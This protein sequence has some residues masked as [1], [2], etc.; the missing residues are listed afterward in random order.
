M[1]LVSGSGFHSLELEPTTSDSRLED[2][3]ICPVKCRLWKGRRFQAN[4][5]V[6]SYRCLFRWWR[7][8]DSAISNTVHKVCHI[9]SGF[10]VQIPVTDPWD[11]RYI[12]HYLPTWKS[13]KSTKCSYIYHTCIL[14]DYLR[15]SKRYPRSLHKE[16]NSTADPCGPGPRFKIAGD[17]WVS[18]TSEQTWSVGIWG[19]KKRTWD[20]VEIYTPHPGFQWQITFFYM[21]YGFPTKNV[22][23]RW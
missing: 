9:L 11:E 21:L 10:L 6:T 23:T 17:C 14:W 8:S 18:G 16:V 4:G 19:A 5:S 1:L 7:P 20:W 13:W 2:L 12:Y 15:S 3:Q 22:I